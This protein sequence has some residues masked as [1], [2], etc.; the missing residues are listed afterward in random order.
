MGAAVDGH[1]AYLPFPHPHGFADATDYIG[2]GPDHP[3][4]GWQV[5]ESQ[6]RLFRLIDRLTRGASSEYDSYL[7]RAGFIVSPDLDGT[8]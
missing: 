1:R 7:N 5:S 8:E 6:A 2:S 4:I 3:P